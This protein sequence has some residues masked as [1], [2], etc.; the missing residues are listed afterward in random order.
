MVVPVPNH[1]HAVEIDIVRHELVAAYNFEESWDVWLRV[2]YEVKR[3]TAS[4]ELIDPA[5]TPTE[6]TA[7]QSNLDLHHPTETLSGLSDVSVLVASR[8]QDVFRDGDM[9]AVAFGTSIPVGR[10]ED[11]PYVLGAAGMPHEHVQ[12]G[13]GSFDPLLECFY[14][15][16]VAERVRASANLQGKFSLYENSKGYRGPVQISSGVSLSFNPTEQL[17]LNAGWS[18]YYQS[19]AHWDGKRD[20]NSGLISN[21]AVG[22]ASYQISDDIYLSL[23]VRIPGSQRALSSSGD[24]FEPGTVA[25]LGVSYSF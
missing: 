1:R 16:P 2:P 23:S 3:R 8:S 20:I 18:F 14:F 22:G 19:Y 15:T 17:S 6:I 11:D 21:G 13:T 5:A 9:L 24:A 4:V 25:Q 7:M 10:T 12:F